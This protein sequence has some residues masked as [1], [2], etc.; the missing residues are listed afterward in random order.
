MIVDADP[1]DL[2]EL[3]HVFDEIKVAV[4]PL[5]HYGR[6][7]GVAADDVVGGCRTPV[8]RFCQPTETL[9]DIPLS[10]LS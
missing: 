4:H 8:Y 3:R 6:K 9:S 10:L 7:A 1:L 5:C 2:G